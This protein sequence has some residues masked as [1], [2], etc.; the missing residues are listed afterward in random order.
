LEGELIVTD[1]SSTARRILTGANVAVLAT[2][3]PDGSP[4]T[5]ATWVHVEEVQPILVTTK[6]TLKYRNL[7]R[8]PRVALTV[9]LRDDPYV[10]LNLRGRINSIEDDEGYVTLSMMSEKYYGVSEYPY[11][12]SQQ[13]WVKML[14][15]IER[16]RSNKEIPDE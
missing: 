11:L 15:D 16:I 7:Q 2:L 3:M 4:H 5:T 12:T 8:D 1:L 9:F 13:E 10:E 6:D 14:I